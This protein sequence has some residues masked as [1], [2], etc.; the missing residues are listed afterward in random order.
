LLG[1]EMKSI[2]FLF[3]AISI[4]LVACTTHPT[5]VEEETQLIVGSEKT[6][7]ELTVLESSEKKRKPE[8]GRPSIFGDL[9]ARLNLSKEQKPLVEQILV[10]HKACTEECVKVLKTAEREILIDAKVKQDAI[11]FALNA[12]EITKEVAIKQLRELKEKTREALKLIP[13]KSNLKEC[14][15]TCDTTFLTELKSLLT[16]EQLIILVK[17]QEIKVKRG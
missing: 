4:F 14:I 8:N 1:E 5:L 2:L 10:K 15:K 13:V 3:S 9:L 12:G 7:Q 16:P 11:K 6:S 17:W